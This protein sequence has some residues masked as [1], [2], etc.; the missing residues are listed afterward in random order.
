MGFGLMIPAVAVL[1]DA[2]RRRPADGRDDVSRLLALPV[3]RRAGA[4]ASI[5]DKKGR[6]PVL[7]FSQVGSVVGYGL[8]AR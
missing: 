8:L 3:A 6:R 1:R 4:L 7:I 2:L 5:S